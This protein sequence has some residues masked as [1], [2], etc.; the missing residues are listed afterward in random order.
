M[1]TSGKVIAFSALVLVLAAVVPAAAS[2]STYPSGQRTVGGVTLEPALDAANGSLV[3]LSTPDGTQQGGQ[4]HLTTKNNAPLWLPVYPADS[5][6]DESLLNCQHLGWDNCPD[7]GPL[8][9]GIAQS[10]GSGTPAFGLGASHAYDVGV[11]GHDHLVGIASTGGDFNVVWV[12]VALFFTDQGVTDGAINHRMTTL[13][14]V[15]TAISNGDVEQ[16]TL[17][18]AA[19]KCASVSV[20]V[21][22]HGT[23]VAPAGPFPPVS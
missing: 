7:H 23:P 15:Q 19:F 9:A 16:L 14:D 3:F 12:P 8:I 22:N 20:A 10:L 17:T 11:L 2:A 21:Y 1:R 13:T 4:V 6:V 5:T 18:P